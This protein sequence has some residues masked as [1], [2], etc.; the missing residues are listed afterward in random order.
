V[1]AG[2]LLDRGGVLDVRDLCDVGVPE[3]DRPWVGVDRD[4]VV[5]SLAR[6]HDRG[7]LVATRPDE[8]ESG[9]GAMLDA[10]SRCGMSVALFGLLDADAEHPRDL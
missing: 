4:D 8:E 7:P 1:S 6:T 2:D 10:R 5:P 9:H 3:G